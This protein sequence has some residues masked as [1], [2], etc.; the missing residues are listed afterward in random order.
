VKILKPLYYEYAKKDKA[1]WL[2]VY[3]IYQKCSY[4]EWL[5]ILNECD[6]P[7]RSWYAKV[8]EFGFKLNFPLRGHDNYNLDAKLH[9]AEP[10]PTI[11][12]DGKGGTKTVMKP[13]E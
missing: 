9:Q 6:I 11:E 12:P 8:E 1:F 3:D 7:A 2:K 5:K 4:G 13:V 10:I